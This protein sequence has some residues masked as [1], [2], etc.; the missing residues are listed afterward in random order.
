M[1][2]S[3]YIGAYWGIREESV[4]QCAHRLAGFMQC[5]AECDSCFAKWFKKGGSRK[6]ALSL[7]VNSDIA[8]LQTLLL[9]GQHRT[10]VGQKIMENL[11][12]L[13]GLWNGANNDAESAGLI[14]SCGSYALRPG[15]QLLH[16]QFAIWGFSYRAIA[17]CAC[18]RGNNEVRGIYMG[19]RLERH[20]V[21]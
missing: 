3:Y 19:S 18:S 8:T 15:F 5:L 16:D 13:I 11:G 6:E 10:D 20:H 1:I 2:E 7:E 12:F 17:A 14:I 4:E 21:R 9:S